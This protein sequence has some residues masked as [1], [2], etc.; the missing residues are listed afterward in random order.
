MPGYRTHL[1]GAGAT[2]VALLALTHWEQPTASLVCLESVWCISASLMGGLFPDI[3]IK[4]KGQKLFYTLLC[5]ILLG[6]LWMR[7]TT[8]LSACGVL[9]VIPPLLPH[10]GITHQ[11]WFIIFIPLAIPFVVASYHPEHLSFATSVYVYFVAG[12]LSHV[13]LDFGVKKSFLSFFK[14]KRK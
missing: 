3:D 9:A 4:S 13:L 7:N 11:P 14:R 2:A 1:S 12:A 8:V 10:R 5:I 6:A